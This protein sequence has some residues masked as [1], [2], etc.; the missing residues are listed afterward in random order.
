MDIKDYR[1]VLIP[2]ILEK[3]RCSMCGECCE[4]KWR[5]DIDEKSYQAVKERLEENKEDVST[6]IEQNE[7]GNY[8]AKF[9]GKYCKFITD[10]IKCRIHRDFGW[11]CLSDTCK[12][13]PRNMRLTS[14]GMEIGLGFSCGSAAKLLLTDEKV[15][16]KKIKKEDYFFMT[17]RDISFIIPENNLKTAVNSRYYEVEEMAIEILNQEKDLFTKLS[18]LERIL[19]GL[20]NVADVRECNFK[21]VIEGLDDFTI[22]NPYTEEYLVDEIIKAIMKKSE[23][24]ESV[25]EYYR[26]LLKITS[27]SGDIKKDRKFLSWSGY[28][29]Y[30]ERLKELKA[31]WNSK[32]DKILQRYFQCYIFNKEIYDNSEYFMFK[33]TISMVMIKLRMLLTI[34]Y[35]GRELTEDEVIAAIKGYEN[36]FSH[37]GD[38]FSEYYKQKYENKEDIKEVTRKLLLMFK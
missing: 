5:I 30:S 38:Y 6:Y 18:Y 17:P 19:A 33:T 20:E 4:S 23:R 27:L 35:L 22:E 1:Y 2:N 16:I 31:L 7:N 25:A 15:S 14:R 3:F 34:K 28:N 36:D 37:D 29:L 21:E 9:D 10:D 13:Y 11:E 32:W 12:I 24:S 8:V 26:S